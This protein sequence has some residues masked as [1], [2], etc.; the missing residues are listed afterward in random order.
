[1]KK[2]RDFH[3]QGLGKSGVGRKFKF[4]SHR[5]LLNW[6][7]KKIKKPTL[8]LLP[9]CE[10][11]YY[12]AECWTKTGSAYNFFMFYHPPGCK[13]LNSSFD[14]GVGPFK[15]WCANK[16]K[17]WSFEVLMADKPKIWFCKWLLATWWARL[18]HIFRTSEIG[19]IVPYPVLSKPSAHH[20]EFKKCLIERKPKFPVRY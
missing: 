13:S 17:S 18:P 7:R 16:A 5:L 1:M 4:Y 2:I 12:F 15:F 9:S 19:G 6:K 20:P 11:L 10:K 14:Q 8:G 3:E